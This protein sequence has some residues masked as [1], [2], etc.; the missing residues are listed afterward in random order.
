MAQ[1]LVL[2]NIHKKLTLLHVSFGTVI[3]CLCQH[4][5]QDGSITTTLPPSLGV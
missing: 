5:M 2:Y 3:A 1:P 4:E